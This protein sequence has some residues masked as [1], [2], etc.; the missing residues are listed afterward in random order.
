MIDSAMN[1]NTADTTIGIHSAEIPTMTT[2]RFGGASSYNLSDET[3][4]P[5]L[6]SFSTRSTSLSFTSIATERL[7]F[8]PPPSGCPVIASGTFRMRLRRIGGNV[9]QQRSKI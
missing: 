8:E 5:V 3:T 7:A 9:F 4:Q 1:T 2:S 6:R